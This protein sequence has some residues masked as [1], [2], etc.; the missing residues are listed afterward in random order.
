MYSCQESSGGDDLRASAAKVL[1]GV[2]G[3][4]A[5]GPKRQTG[6]APGEDESAGADQEDP[7]AGAGEQAAGGEAN[8]EI[9][10]LR[11]SNSLQ[12]AHS[13]A[14]HH[15]NAQKGLMQLIS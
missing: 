1:F 8:A 4:Q 11:L 6:G 5:G 15:H 2:T 9:P 10:G 13:V 7:S 3:W 12:L 14:S